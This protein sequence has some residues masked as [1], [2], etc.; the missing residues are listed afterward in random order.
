MEH[1]VLQRNGQ[2]LHAVGKVLVEGQDGS[3]MLQARDGVIWLIEAKEIERRTTNNEP[4]APLP[5]EELKARVLGQLPEGFKV[6]STVHYQIFYNTSPAYAQWCGSL[7]ERLH[8]GFFVYWRSRGLKLTEPKHPLVAL[9]F[10]DRASFAAHGREELG[11]GIDKMIGYYNFRTNHM[12]LFDLTGRDRLVDLTPRG[13][14]RG[15]ARINELLSQPAAERL[16]A[17]VVHEATHQLAY[18]SGLQTR[19]AGNPFWF[20]EGLAMYFEVPDLSKSKGWKSIGRLN[21][22]QLKRYRTSA[23]AEGGLAALI[24]DEKR[25][26]D[27]KTWDRAYADSWALTYYLLKTRPKKYVTYA[28][29]L[30]LLKPQEELNSQQRLKQFK[31]VFGDLDRLEQQVKRYMRRQR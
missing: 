19:Y 8:R 31:D 24:A 11:D 9:I 20:S 4:Y 30:S 18:N 13:R 12:N 22:F 25:F 2:K 15:S 28:R 21:R 27:A 14:S 3:L 10:R 26:Q 6:H 5:I 29:K 23:P 16:V 7:F 17:T 1:V